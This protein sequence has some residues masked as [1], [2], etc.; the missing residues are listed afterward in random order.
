VIFPGA[1]NEVEPARNATGHEQQG[2]L[3]PQTPNGQTDRSLGPALFAGGE[4]LEHV[5]VF[6]TAPLVGG[7]LAAVLQP[8]LYARERKGPPV[9]A[10]EPATSEA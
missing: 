4:P 7:V 3:N 6:L 1:I 5:W 2:R 8:W 9:Q 10:Q